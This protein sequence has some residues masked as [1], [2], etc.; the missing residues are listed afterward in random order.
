MK[1]ATRVVCGAATA[2]LAGCAHQFLVQAQNECSAF[3]FAAGTSEYAS[4]V[5]Q[6]YVAGRARFQQGMMNASRSFSGA[7]YSSSYGG[8]AAGKGFLKNSYISGMNRICVYDRL[9]SA[10]VVTV[11][12][13]DMCPMTAP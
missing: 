9:G 5:Q 12:A 10:Y 7:D 6:Q 3:G 13:A 1:I 4:C 8:R 2:L 11:G